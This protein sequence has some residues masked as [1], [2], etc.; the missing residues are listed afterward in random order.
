MVGFGAGITVNSFSVNSATQMTANISIAGDAAPGARDVSV[1]GPVGT[2]TLPDGFRVTV[3][4]VNIAPL[5][6]TASAD[7]SDWM[8]AGGAIDGDYASM[9]NAGSHASSSNPHWLEV[10]LQQNRQVREIAVNSMIWWAG[11]QYPGLTNVY[12]LYVSSDGSSWTLIGSGTLTDSTDPEAYS[13]RHILSD[14]M[15]AIRYVKYEVVGGT[16]WAHLV[17]MEVLVNSSTDL[18]PVPTVTSVGPDHGAQGQT[19]AV[20]I[21]GTNFTGATAV[22][23]GNDVT[24]NSFTVYSAT[25]ITANISIS[26]AATPG[27]RTVV[28]DGAYL[29]SGFMVILS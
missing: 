11:D 25:Q 20:T 8:A 6:G 13:D 16:H 9:W 29:Q 24:V 18:P 19:L 17:E 22:S 26:A 1:T 4:L 23:F 10:D 27:A 14:Q 2:G 15:P 3:P 5:Y 21:N 28:V 12:N 7:V